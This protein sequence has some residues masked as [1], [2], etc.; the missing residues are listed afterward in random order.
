MA[1]MRLVAPKLEK[2]KQQYGDDREKLNHAMMDLYK[3]EKDQSAG[4]LSA[5]GDPDSGVH[6]AVLGDLVQRGT[7]PRAVLRLDTLTCR[8][9][10]PTTSCRSSWVS[11]CWFK[12]SL[13][14]CRRIRCRPSSCRSCPS[15]SA[16]CS[17]SSRPDLVLYSV[18]NNI[19][20]IAQQWYITRGQKAAHKGWRQS[21][22]T[23]RRL[24]PPLGAVA[25]A[26]C[27]FPG[28]AWPQWPPSLTGRQLH[29]RLATYTSFLA[30]DGTIL[31]QGIALFF[32]APHSYTGEEVLELQGHGGPAVLQSVLH[33]CLELGARLAQ[34]G[35]FTQRAFLND[36]MDLAQ[37]ES[38]ADLIDATTEQAARS[39]MRSLQGEFSAAIQQ[40]SCQAYRFAHAGRGNAGFSGRRN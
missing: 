40:C 5:H 19:L 8:R 33:R 11:A 28:E 36:K 15:C 24:P 26:W 22:T 20:S 2:I 27:E 18:V 9:P 37:A 29:P 35:E 16:S 38:V 30:A 13:I 14:R 3:T 7:A 34:P 21:L 25:S 39:A 1:K 32:P 23:S 10:I 4:W 31:D 17:S 12:A 6:C